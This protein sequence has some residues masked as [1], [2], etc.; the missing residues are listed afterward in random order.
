[1]AFSSTASQRYESV[2]E[3]PEAAGEA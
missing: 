3:H 2:V 1:M